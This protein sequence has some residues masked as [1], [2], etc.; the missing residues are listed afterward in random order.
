MKKHVLV[1]DDEYEVSQAVELILEDEGYLVTSCGDGLEA[2]EF[3]RKNIPAL[4]ISD[5]MMPLCNGYALLEFIRDEENLSRVP[6]IL[7][8]AAQLKDD[9]PEP[10]EFMKKPFD[11]ETLL[12]TVEKVIGK[13]S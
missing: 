8:S 13:A 2:K 12:Y 4:V 5:V 9:S 6:V 10:D 11:L 3:L 7:M 1:V